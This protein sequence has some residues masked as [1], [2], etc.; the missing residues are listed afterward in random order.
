MNGDSGMVPRLQHEVVLQPSWQRSGA[1]S[2]RPRWLPGDELFQFCNER[3]GCI[4]ALCGR[5]Q[6]CECS[7]RSEFELNHFLDDVIAELWVAELK[8]AIGMEWADDADVVYAA[9]SRN[10]D[11]HETASKLLVAEIYDAFAECGALTLVNRDG[12][13]ELQW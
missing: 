1:S 13:G 7:D 10:S 8:D 3:V 9:C 6:L 2:G 4:Q 11:E 5:L 12:I